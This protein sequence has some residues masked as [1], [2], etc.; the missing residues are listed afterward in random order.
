[1]SQTKAPISP[2]SIVGFKPFTGCGQYGDN[3]GIGGCGQSDENDGLSG[4]V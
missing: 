1:M 4:C 3:D 2:Q